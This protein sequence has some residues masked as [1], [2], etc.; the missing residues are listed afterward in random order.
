MRRKDREITDRTEQDALLHR[1]SVLHMALV[2]NG[3]PYIVPLNYGYDGEYMY[4]HCIDKGMKL[5][6]LDANNRVALNVLPYQAMKPMEELKRACNIGMYYES[7]TVFGRAHRVTDPAQ[8]QRA[9]AALIRQ[10]KAEHLP[11]EDNNPA[12]VVLRVE[13]EEITAKRSIRQG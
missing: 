13:I 12:V 1:G 11:L 7:V 10:H 8:R 3:K 2:D 4:M 9:F 5:D 6:I